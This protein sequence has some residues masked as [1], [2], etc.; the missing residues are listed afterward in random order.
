MFVSVKKTV[1]KTLLFESVG[2][3]LWIKSMLEYSNKMRLLFTERQIAS[4]EG[5]R[6]NPGGSLEAAT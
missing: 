4:H 2:L 6:C 3:N 1:V 5:K